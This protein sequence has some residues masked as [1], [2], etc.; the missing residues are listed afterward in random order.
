MRW[1]LADDKVKLSTVTGKGVIQRQSR[2]TCRRAECQTHP[3]TEETKW[4][5]RNFSKSYA[6]KS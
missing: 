5:T 3:R 2:V 6:G 1:P 4:R